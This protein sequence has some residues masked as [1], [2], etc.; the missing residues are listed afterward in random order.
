VPPAVAEVRQAT[1]RAR[2]AARPPAVDVV[3]RAPAPLRIERLTAEW[4][5]REVVHGLDLT[6]E[7]GEI[8]AIMG[9]NGSGKSTVLGCA[10]GSKDPRSGTVSVAGTDPR[11]LS[12][13][14][15]TR[16]VGL[17]PQDPSLLLYTSS[18]AEECE[19]ADVESGLESGTTRAR[20]A[21]LTDTIDPGTHPRDLSEGQR[22]LLAL[23]VVTAHRP[24]LLLL[25]EP[26]RGL[27]YEAKHRLV[28]LLDDMARS[29][30]A[31][32]V[33]THDVELVAHLAQRV[34][35]LAH[36]EII[37]DGPAA[38]VVCHS[39][40]L[41]PQVA[42]IVAPNPILTLA[43]LQAALGMEPPTADEVR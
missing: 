27:D 28:R 25:D 35:V 13:A 2:P 6:V 17:V 23:A 10:V 37:A 11:A 8:L 14:R 19:L 32:V 39:P 12:G 33:A 7:G 24:G 9:R 41:A 18:A 36:G 31:V 20:L 42:K 21:E 4:A 5:G 1:A 29:G 30:T 16:L 40:T 15:L 34:L 43:E 26:T 38:D 3:P 22:L